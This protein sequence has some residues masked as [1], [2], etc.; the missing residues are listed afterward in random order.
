[1][2]N[3]TINAYTRSV[4]TS[5]GNR[6]IEEEVPVSAVLT[7]K[8]KGKSSIVYKKT[9]PTELAIKKLKDFMSNTYTVGI[10]NLRVPLVHVGDFLVQGVQ[11]YAN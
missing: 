9:V 6:W 1:M 11:L 10:D 5:W 3:Q 4:P 2:F 8:I 7:L